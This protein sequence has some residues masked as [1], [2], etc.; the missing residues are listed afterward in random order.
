VSLAG[1]VTA[2]AVGACLPVAALVLALEARR[3]RIL[4]VVEGASMAP[5]LGDGDRVLV[6]R[7]AGGT[8]RT[9]QIALVELPVLT[10][11]GWRWPPPGHVRWASRATLTIKRVA[12]V[13]GDP[14]P[15]ELAAALPSADGRVPPG[16]LVVLGDGPASVDSRQWGYVPLE[17]VR[18]VAVRTLPRRN[19]S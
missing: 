1:S 18:G 6:K 17:R 3:R 2:V 14:V 11:A 15:R 10:P 4:I 9:G 7:L 16:T 12:A 5:T 13:A 19:H 8:P